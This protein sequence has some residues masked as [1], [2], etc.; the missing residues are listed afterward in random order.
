[1]QLTATHIS[2]YQV[3]KRKLW[4]FANE[5]RMEHTS[6]T[7][8]E[9]KLIHET[10]YPQ[11]AE[12]YREIQIDGCKIDFY[13]PYNKVVHEIKKSDK[14]EQAHVA[15]VKYYLYVL[16]RNGIEE[17]TGI[18]EYPKLRKRDEVLLEDEDKAEIRRW[19][20]DIERIANSPVCPPLLNKP[21]CKQCSYFDFCY[22]KE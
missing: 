2:Y 18:L 5:V 17:A 20:Q 12:R 1:M 14:V 3:C 22:A 4:L 6:D 19:E 15:Q 10:V 13:D 16:D 7:V 21:I 9:G 8:A 11:R